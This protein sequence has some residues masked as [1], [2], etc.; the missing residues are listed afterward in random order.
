M[1][2]F[3]VNSLRVEDAAQARILED[4]INRPT[5]RNKIY[6]KVIETLNKEIRELLFGRELKSED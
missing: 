1:K 6:D 5:F 2:L 3:K 4:L